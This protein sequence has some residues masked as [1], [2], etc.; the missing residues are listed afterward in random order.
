MLRNHPKTNGERQDD[1]QGTK[2]VSESE[3][4]VM[5]NDHVRSSRVKRRSCKSGIKQ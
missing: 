1:R 2:S 4:K 5:N 3:A